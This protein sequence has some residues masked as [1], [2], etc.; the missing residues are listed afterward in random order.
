M[1]N[2]KLTKI[3]LTVWDM[4]AMRAFYAAFFGVAFTPGKLGPFDTYSA[5][6]PG[7]FRL[8]LVPQELTGSTANQ[9]RFQLNLEHDNVSEAVSITLESGGTLVGE[10][11]VTHG[12]K[13]ASLRD[14]DGNYLVVTEASE[15]AK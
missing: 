14:P 3:D 1:P 11:S 8:H 13:T 7:L 9:N 5:D 4:P 2:L 6:V 10:V 15:G 12:V